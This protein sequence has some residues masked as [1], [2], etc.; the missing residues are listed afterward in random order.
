MIRTFLFLLVALLLVV[1]QVTV[2]DIIF[3]GK[4]G[5]ELSLILVVYAGFFLG[6][7]EG[8]VVSFILGFFL[9]CLT[10]TVSGLFTMLYGMVFIVTALFS[11]R[12]YAEKILFIAL[13]T[14]ACAL[15]E[16]ILLIFFF[17]IIYG[18]NTLHNLVSIFLPQALVAGILSPV[19]FEIFR[20]VEGALNA[21]HTE[22]AERS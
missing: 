16:G 22:S 13:Y 19:L 1:F 15:A 10:G 12:V 7:V 17:R 20:R 5:V 14:S 8:A 3:S 4:I 6:F 2:P 18:V 21:G 9:D 11:F